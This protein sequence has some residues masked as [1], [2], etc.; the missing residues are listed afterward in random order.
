M[1]QPL[2]LPIPSEL[3]VSTDGIYR[4]SSADKI[5][6]P[7]PDYLFTAKTLQSALKDLN[8]YTQIIAGDILTAGIRLYE[9]SDL[10][11][12]GYT[13]KIDETGIRIEGA[14][15]GLFYGICTLNQLMM[16]YGRDLPFMIIS[17][18]PDFPAR[19]VMLDISRDKVPTMETL[20]GLVD[21][22]ASLKINQLQLYIEHTFAYI[23][24]EKVWA[25]A[26]PMTAQ[27]IMEL[28]GYC[29]EHYVE[30]VPNQNSLGHMER[31]LKF[32]DYVT[33]AETPD[34]F[35]PDWGGPRRSAST[36]DPLDPNSFELIRS[37][38]DQYLPNFSSRTFNVGCDEPWELGQGK[39]KE[40]VE[41]RGGRVYLDW[42]LKLYED[43]SARGYQMMFWG[44]IINHHPDLVPELPDDIIVMEWGYEADHDFDGHC[45]VFADSGIPFYVCPG[46]SAWNTLIGRTE[47]AMGNLRNA[48][49][50][51]LKYGAIGYLNTVW[52]D[53][54]HM[55]PLSVSYLGFAYGA[56]LSWGYE[57][58]RD[59]D[60]QSALSRFMFHDTANVMGQL[61]YDFGKAFHELDWD[62]NFNGHLL[63]YLTKV[64]YIRDRAKSEDGHQG[65]I[66]K[67][68][69]HHVIDHLA[70]LQAGL[71]ETTMQS[72]EGEIVI[73]EYRQASALMQ[74]TAKW[75][76]FIRGESEQSAQDLLLELDSLLTN[77]RETWLIRNR[78]GGLEDSIARFDT[79]REDYSA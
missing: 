35:Q 34:G 43:V 9:N 72:A 45:K 49:E 7:K 67:A 69:L 1:T 70:D 63:A 58:N 30:L 11:E 33:M 55:Q 37:L 41:A 76:L 31:W 48:A 36:L 32:P 75:L 79:M 78:R 54:G 13:L 57:N 14:D 56:A 65:E 66:S 3:Q 40:A 4:L 44:D 51:G 53:N 18:A 28:D 8:L 26:S 73:K 6:I 15:A 60:I 71:V 17:D 38:F 25:L 5:Q 61:A 59:V 27:E 52:G 19:G 39:S 24:H 10:P 47:N 21:K 46:T 16:H 12:Q 2:L 77:Q 23:G 20:F 64:P 62:K 74:H 29:R 42:M 22:L 68:N 50:N